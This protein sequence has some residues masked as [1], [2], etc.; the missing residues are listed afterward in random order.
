MLPQQQI[1]VTM[2]VIVHDRDHLEPA[3]G[4][5]GRSLEAERH[6]KHLPAA[7]AA[8]LLLCCRQQ[9]RPQSLP[10]PCVLYPELTNFCPTAPRIPTD[11]GDDPMVVVPHQDRHPL[12][13]PDACRGG[14][15]LVDPILQV[16][17]LVRRGLGADEEFRSQF[18]NPFEEP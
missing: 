10:A 18:P 13:V 2:R 17:N 9:P 11:P 1:L 15:E 4:I 14:V 16:L 7:T 5:E 3:R 12:P 6:E 8:R